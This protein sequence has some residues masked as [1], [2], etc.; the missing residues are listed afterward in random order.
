[1]AWRKC[2]GLSLAR[3]LN[4]YLLL[5]VM[6]SC[7]TLSVRV[8]SFSFAATT[9]QGHLARQQGIRLQT[10]NMH[11]PMTLH[12]EA[13]EGFERPSVPD[14]FMETMEMTYGKTQAKVKD[15]VIDIEGAMNYFFTTNVEWHPI[16]RSM[17]LSRDEISSD[18]S[19][20]TPAHSYL[21]MEEYSEQ[22]NLEFDAS[23]PWKQLSDIPADDSE[24]AVI[25]TW[26]DAIQEALLNI[27]V[28]ESNGDHDPLDN[29]FVMEGKRMLATS[30]FHVLPQITGD[31]I[32][33]R[34]KL[35]MTCWSEMAELRRANEPDT[36]KCSPCYIG[37]RS[38]SALFYSA[39]YLFSLFPFQNTSQ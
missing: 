21:S 16:F 5:A 1:M 19:S 13:G 14:N 27:P 34:D 29:H 24:R 38:V 32:T 25:G 39:P 33:H 11:R 15:V 36:G 26:L 22:V 10:D 17:L 7:I 3:A 4:A 8:S 35:F 12:M 18:D 28:D 37:T 23:S 6:V 30:R 31:D 9:R 20:T 2:N